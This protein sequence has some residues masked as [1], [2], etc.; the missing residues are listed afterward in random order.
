[1]NEN[2]FDYDDRQSGNVRQLNI[3]DRRNWQQNVKQR[4]K[5]WRLIGRD[6][7]LLH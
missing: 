5:G 1:M 3:N 4:T 2:E 7:T 6:T